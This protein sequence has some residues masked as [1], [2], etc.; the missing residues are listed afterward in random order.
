MFFFFITIH[1]I[2]LVRGIEYFKDV[3]SMKYYPYTNYFY[4]YI[5]DNLY[6]S[7]LAKINDRIRSR[8]EDMYGD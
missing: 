6:D 3:D 7:P 4:E 2:S 8:N 5:T 1:G